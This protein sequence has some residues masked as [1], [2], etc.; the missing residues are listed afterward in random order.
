MKLS[1][2]FSFVFSFSCTGIVDFVFL[3]LTTVEA[4][5]KNENKT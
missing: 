1:F 3:L 4:N 2:V 5:P